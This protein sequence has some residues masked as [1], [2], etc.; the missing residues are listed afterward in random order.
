MVFTGNRPCHT[1]MFRKVFSLA[2]KI[3]PIWNKPEVVS[4]LV[5]K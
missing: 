5:H 2:V 1:P 4:N 3:P